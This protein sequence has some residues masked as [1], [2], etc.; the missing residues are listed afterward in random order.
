M[1]TDGN[2]QKSPRGNANRRS[3]ELYPKT[4]VM[5]SSYFY[6]NLHSIDICGWSAVPAKYADSRSAIPPGVF[7]EDEYCPS[8][9]MSE[10]EKLITRFE[11]V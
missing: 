9:F 11:R 10:K 7:G 8:T 1:G 4:F 2:L 3:H 5:C 6:T